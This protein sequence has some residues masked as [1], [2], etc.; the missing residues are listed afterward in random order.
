MAKGAFE[1]RVRRFPRCRDLLA[2]N[3]L[4]DHCN[5]DDS[6]CVCLHHPR[7]FDRDEAMEWYRAL[8]DLLQSHGAPIGKSREST[9]PARAHQYNTACFTR[10]PCSYNYAGTGKHGQHHY[11]QHASEAPLIISKVERYLCTMFG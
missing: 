3:A 9:A 6:R 5:D 4:R 1:E 11:G 7:F 10:C 2:G 8:L